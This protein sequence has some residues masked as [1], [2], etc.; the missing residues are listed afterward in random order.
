MS[1]EDTVAFKQPHLLP[2]GHSP[3]HLGWKEKAAGAGRG[4]RPQGVSTLTATL[5]FVMP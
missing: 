1:Q 5:G 2:A 3:T 4:L